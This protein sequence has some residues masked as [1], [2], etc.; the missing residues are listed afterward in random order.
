LKT[1]IL[2]LCRAVGLFRLAKWTHRKRL[3]IVCYH[4]IAVNGES[5]FRPKLFMELQNF[6]SRMQFLKKTGMPVLP[7]REATK[8]LYSGGLPDNSVVI[9][10]D[11]GFYS[12]YL[13]AAPVLKAHNFPATVYITTYYVLKGAPIY[14]LFI[15]YA[16][17]RTK[18]V[19]LRE[20]E[21]VRE[22][23]AEVDLTDR[24]A[25]DRAMW[26]LIK[27]G[28][29]RSVEEQ[30]AVSE[31]LG[32]ALDVQYA[33]VKANRALSLMTP[34]EIRNLEQF[35]VDV[36][37]HTHRHRLPLNRES[38]L[39]EIE[40]NRNALANLTTSPLD[41]LCY[42]SGEWSSAQWPWLQ[43]TKV[44]TATTCDYGFND[45]STHPL[46]L[47]RF[48]DGED[49]SLIEFE[50]GIC[51]FSEWV[52]TIKNWFPGKHRDSSLLNTTFGET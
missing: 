35:G 34:A 29:E 18:A 51:G 10:V 40:S 20:S 32:K 42:P 31:R 12:T 5:A 14:R 41:H 50:A 3:C 43:E 11:D 39:Q 7:L 28:E 1:A 22:M 13:S 6:V 21:V 23:A 25:R 9:T 16:F 17:W 24:T 19:R 15:Q 36:Q 2:K 27:Y 49:L 38:V 48:L 33:F 45:S 47:R 30:E 44:L 8:L 46:A 4:G 37:L 52:Q 26:D